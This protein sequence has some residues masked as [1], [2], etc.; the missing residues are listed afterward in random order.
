[1]SDLTDGGPAFPTVKSD[2]DDD[3]K[4]FNFSVGGMSLRD[5]FAGQALAGICARH[6]YDYRQTYA[7]RAYELADAM[8]RVRKDH[9]HVSE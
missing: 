1:M 5:Y 3:G 2:W 8:L 9:G 6:D 7:E 4:P